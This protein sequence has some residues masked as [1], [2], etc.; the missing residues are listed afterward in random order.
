[1][2]LVCVGR[3]K[4]EAIPSKSVWRRVPERCP[5]R[6]NA[7]KYQHISFSLVFVEVSALDKHSYHHYQYSY[8]VINRVIIIASHGL[9]VGQLRETVWHSRGLV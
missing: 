3:P 9:R 5:M 2:I 7:S 8:H 1:M 6:K 4:K